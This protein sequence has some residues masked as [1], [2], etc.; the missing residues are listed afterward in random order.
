MP[1]APVAGE[2]EPAL[3][4]WPHVPQKRASSTRSAPQL[5][6]NESLMSILPN[7]RALDGARPTLDGGC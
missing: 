6:Q 5:M 7:G 1:R 4:G 3:N 2:D